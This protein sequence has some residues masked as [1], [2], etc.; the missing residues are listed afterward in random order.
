MHRHDTRIDL[1]EWW[2]RHH[3]MGGYVA[4]CYVDWDIIHS[5]LAMLVDLFQNYRSLEERQVLKFAGAEIID[6]K[7]PY[8]DILEDGSKIFHLSNELEVNESLMYVP[9]IIHEPWHNRYRVH[10]GSGRL[11]ALWLCGY[12]TFRTVY[13]HFDEPGFEP[14]GT[15]LKLHSPIDLI[16]NCRNSSQGFFPYLDV[17]TYYAFP[18]DE[19]ERFKTT[20]MDSEWDYSHTD[21]M[22]PW[23]FF[24]YSEG[25]NFLN[26]KQAW[27]SNAWV[28]WSELQDQN[29]ILGDTVFH[30]QGNRITEITRKGM[31]LNVIDK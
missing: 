8:R 3:S 28:L 6:N 25:K 27:R 29:F 16:M 7:M 20:T 21:T 9:Q 19:V 22:M 18:Q 15:A 26:F 13:T 1:D 17:Q 12:E 30:F 14:P 23:E 24:R 11:T 2:E 5:P 4:L 31:T 10:P